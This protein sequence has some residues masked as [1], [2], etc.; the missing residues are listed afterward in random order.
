M[1]IAGRRGGFTAFLLDADSLA[2]LRKGALESL[3]GKADCPH[4]RRRVGELGARVP[5]KACVAGHSASNVAPFDSGNVRPTS[6]GAA[7][8]VS[9]FSSGDEALRPEMHN[10]GACP[11]DLADGL[12]QLT[13]PKRFG[14]RKC[15]MV[16]NAMHSSLKKA[17]GF[18]KRIHVNWGLAHPC[19]R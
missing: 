14:A 11:P 13:V 12:S 6:R 1:E 5:L 18:A 7:R 15:V 16:D 9:W 2:L 10:G 8:S 17:G 19:G 4:N 3:G